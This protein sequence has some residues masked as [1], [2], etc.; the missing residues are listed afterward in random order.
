[1]AR[2]RVLLT[3]VLFVLVTAIFVA[4]HVRRSRGGAARAA[5]RVNCPRCGIPVAG[6]SV[7]CPKCGV[8]PQVFEVVA[9]PSVAGSA[10]ETSA[11]RLHAVVRGNVCVGCGACVSVCPEPGAISLVGKLA[12]VNPALC[13]THGECVRACPVQA[14]FLLTG[15]AGQK[16]EVP[17]V[18]FDFETNVRGVFIVGELGGRGLIKNAINEGKLAAQA[19]ARRAREGTGVAGSGLV[20]NV[21]IVGSGPAGL[22]AALECHRQSLRYVVL[23]QGDAVE[24]I[25]RYPRRKLL[26]AEPVNLP[27]VGDLWVAD[28]SKETL[29]EIWERILHDTGVQIRTGQKVSDVKSTPWGFD[30]VTPAASWPARHVILAMGRRGS[31]RKL[32]VAG[33]E[34]PKVVYDIVE[35][36][37]F[38]GR[39]VLVIGGGDSAVESAV[40][41]ARQAGTSV[42]LSYR[43]E[44]FDRVKERNRAK[45]DEAVKSGRVRLVLGLTVAEIRAGCVQLHTPVGVI[46]IPNDDVVVRIGG[47]PPAA[48]LD[49]IGVRRVVK[50]LAMDSAA[51]A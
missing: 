2:R 5:T 48:F 20:H 39:R 31:P 41:L 47:E 24:S 51:G 22:S 14:I 49:R 40:G 45:L 36:D 38:Q 3:T 34:L 28:A 25:R 44:G 11:G 29:L 32:D 23:E 37:A 19:V 43:G 46:E 9:A 26:L 35:M 21:V 30:V 50:E 10:G 18:D 42:H 13:K 8:P 33:E 4:L 15:C 6:S 16:V 7:R 12:V 17:I 27:I 1:M